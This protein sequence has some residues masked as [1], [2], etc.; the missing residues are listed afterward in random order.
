MHSETAIKIGLKKSF[1]KA[2]DRATDPDF[3]L[4]QSCGT[5]NCYFNT[6]ESTDS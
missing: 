6:F 2:K 1:W 5:S 4:I 3:L